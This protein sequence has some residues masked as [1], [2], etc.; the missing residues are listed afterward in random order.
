MVGIDQENLELI[1]EQIVDRFPVDSS[2]LHG[3]MGNPAGRE[4]V[5]KDEKIEAH[6]A[7]S[8]DVL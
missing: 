5:T 7:E 2:T 4:P 6:G 8:L 3:H 1:F